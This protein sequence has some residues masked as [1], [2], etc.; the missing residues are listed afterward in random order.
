RCS[1]CPTPARPSKCPCRS[2]APPD[3]RFP[4]RG[5]PCAPADRLA[6]PGALR[7]RPGCPPQSSLLNDAA[8]ELREHAQHLEQRLAGRGA[9]VDALAIEVEIYSGAFQLAQEA[10]EVLQAAAAP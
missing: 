7:A 3:G 5:D 1:P 4:G 8:L 10:H 6:T 9:R 2:P